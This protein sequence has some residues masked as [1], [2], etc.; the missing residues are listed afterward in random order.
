MQA[1]SG[2]IVAFI[3]ISCLIL[4][5]NS[6]ADVEEAADPPVG[7]DA[8]VI[9][10]ETVSGEEALG[11]VLSLPIVRVPSEQDDACDRIVPEMQQLR[12]YLDL[13]DCDE[14]AEAQS[15]HG[16][17]LAAIQGL[18]EQIEERDKI[19]VQLNEQNRT[20]ADRIVTLETER[21]KEQAQ[22]ARMETRLNDA[23]TTLERQVGATTV[24][25]TDQQSG[26]LA[27]RLSSIETDRRGEQ[28][29]LN[30]IESRLDTSLSS[31]EGRTRD[32]QSRM[33]RLESRMM[34]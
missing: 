11:I 9:A 14:A 30:R 15:L 12:E 28:S 33:S 21:R 2:F 23:L 1:R 24:G 22:F 6:F 31:I 34:T 19:L 18:Y 27:S 29:R 20:L 17:S 5:A 8:S 13:G 16:L 10:D 32:L 26:Q 4:G 7:T 3:S 25:G